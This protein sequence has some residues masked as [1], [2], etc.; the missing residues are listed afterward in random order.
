MAYFE[1]E[2]HPG[3]RHFPFGKGHVD[4][5]R[6]RFAMDESSVFRMPILPQVSG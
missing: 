1:C 2:F 3:Q 6:E 5:L 4:A